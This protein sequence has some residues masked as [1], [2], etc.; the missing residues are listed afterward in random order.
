MFLGPKK[1]SDA[2]FCLIQVLHTIT[3]HY[4]LSTDLQIYLTVA[5]S[6]T[7]M[8]CSLILVEY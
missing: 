2:G 8:Q 6:S 4:I 5:S 1:F 7:E 3:Q